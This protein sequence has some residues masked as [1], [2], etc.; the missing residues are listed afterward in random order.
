[1]TDLGGTVEQALSE[2]LRQQDGS[3]LGRYVLVAETIEQ[4]GS[5]TTLITC[6]DQQA[7][8]ESFGLLEFGK[9]MEYG[10]AQENRD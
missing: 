6:P 9:S 4:D 7:P 10:A 8:W 2:A 3:M 1:M 5:R